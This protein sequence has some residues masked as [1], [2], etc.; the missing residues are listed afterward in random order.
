[1][2]EIIRAYSSLIPLKMMLSS[3]TEIV[4]KLL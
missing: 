4:E 2:N 1:M 3:F